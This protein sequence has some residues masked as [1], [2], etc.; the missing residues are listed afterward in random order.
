MRLDDTSMR[1]GLAST[2]EALRAVDA[3][4]WTRLS[5]RCSA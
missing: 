1:D 2:E 4:F 3:G 5:A